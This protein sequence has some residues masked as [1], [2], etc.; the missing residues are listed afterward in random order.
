MCWR[1]TLTMVLNASTDGAW[2]GED[3][4]ITLGGSLTSRREVSFHH[5]VPVHVLEALGSHQPG[6][7]LA[8]MAGA[9]WFSPR[10]DMAGKCRGGHSLCVLLRV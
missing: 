4:E 7:L 2:E 10:A 6:R 1:T 8:S 9:L 5:P 3:L